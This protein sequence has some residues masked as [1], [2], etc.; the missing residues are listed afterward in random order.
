[1]VTFALS[2]SLARYTAG[3]RVTITEGGTLRELIEK[4]T[5]EFPDLHSRVWSP[6]GEVHPYLALFWNDQRITNLSIDEVKPS[7]GDLVEIMTLAS[8]G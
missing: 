6:R 3:D 1:M 7:A 5:T 2:S 8:G 4:L